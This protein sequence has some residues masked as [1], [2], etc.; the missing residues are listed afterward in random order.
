MSKVNEIIVEGYLL[1]DETT[2][3]F[4]E[5]CQH[6]HIPQSLLDEM[7]ECGLIE[8]NQSAELKLDRASLRRVQTALCL[9]N[10]LQINLAGAALILEL[11]SELKKAQIEL[12]ML[13]KYVQP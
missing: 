2:F 7:I 13:Q 10:D 9:Q 6:Y 8:S 3:S 12:A 4:T 11:Q 1:D 5:I